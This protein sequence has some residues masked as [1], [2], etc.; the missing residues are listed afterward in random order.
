MTA[1][2]I[3]QIGAFQQFD[4]HKNAQQGLGLGL[5]LVQKLAVRN[6]ARFAIESEPSQKTTVIVAFKEK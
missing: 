1:A 4:R 6:G 5:I 2:E 3:E